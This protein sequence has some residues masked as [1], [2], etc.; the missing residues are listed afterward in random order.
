MLLFPSF[1]QQ[2]FQH[3]HHFLPRSLLEES[4]VMKDP[5]TSDKD[6]FLILGSR[7]SVCSRLVCVGPV[8]LQLILLQEILPPL[9][10]GAH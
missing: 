5:F 4:Y 2:K 7:C 10:P 3:W 9:C 1:R 6:K 8:G